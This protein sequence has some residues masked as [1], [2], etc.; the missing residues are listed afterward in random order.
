MP[1]SRWGAF[2]LESISRAP[3]PEGKVRIERGFIGAHADI[4]GGYGANE[5]QLAQVALEWMVKQAVAAGVTMD[6]A[7]HTVIAQPILHD[8]SKNQN[9]PNGRPKWEDRNVHYRDGTIVKQRDMDLPGMKFRDTEQFITYSRVRWTRMGNG[10]R[11]MKKPIRFFPGAIRPGRR[12]LLWIATL[13]PVLVA[14]ARGDGH[15][16]H[17]GGNVPVGTLYVDASTNKCGVA[18]YNDK[19]YKIGGGSLHNLRNVELAS[20][21]GGE[22]GL[23][24][25]I[26]A[27]WFTCQPTPGG[28]LTG[29]G[30][31]LAGDYTAPVAERI[32]AEVVDFIRTKGGSL[33]LKIR[34]VDNGVLIGWDVEKI[35]PTAGWKP[36]DGPSGVHYYMAGGDFCEQQVDAERVV[37]PGWEHPPTS[38]NNMI[39]KENS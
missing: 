26:R 21:P 32:P 9:A 29:L 16:L 23:P 4:G 22:L 37:K 27:T 7:P 31:T 24:A 39:R 20:F 5:N 12:S 3:I 1:G 25:S 13:V 14:C 18:I 33:R 8:M 35:V 6:D 34:L 10:T 19:G 17:Q 15:R 11:T 36:G 2:P 38:I 30:G 28:G